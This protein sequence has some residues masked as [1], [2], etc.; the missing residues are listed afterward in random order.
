M[1]GERDEMEKQQRSH[2]A[3]G[4]TAVLRAN[5]MGSPEAVQIFLKPPRSGMSKRPQAVSAANTVTV[6][7]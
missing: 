1:D 3:Q 5:Q 6:F 7:V 4:K 2:R